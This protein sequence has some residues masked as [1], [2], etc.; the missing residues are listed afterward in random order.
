M[1]N[2][3]K[4]KYTAPISKKDIKNYK[5]IKAF[6]KDDQGYKNVI[7]PYVQKRRRS[8]TRA[9]LRD[10]HGAFDIFIKKKPAAYM[11]NLSQFLTDEINLS[12]LLHET[13]L[14]IK[15]VTKASGTLPQ[16]KL[17]CGS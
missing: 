8:L 7:A 11:A 14:V 5:L 1:D 12:E 16:P 13:S 2:E 15:T 10:E 4:S 3:Q 6:L 9:L 17:K